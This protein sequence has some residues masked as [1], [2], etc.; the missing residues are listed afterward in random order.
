[1]SDQKVIAVLGATGNQGGSVADTF[2][3]D[4]WRVRTITRN[5][6][7]PK[8]QEL[9]AR[10]AEIA[11]ADLDS[12]SSLRT[13][14]EGAHVVF[15]VSDFWGLYRDPSNADKPRQGQSLNAWAAEHETEQLRNVI[16]AVAGI[17]CVERFIFSSLSGATKWSKGKYTHVYHF[18]SKA[19]AED[20]GRE[21]YPDL[22]KTSILQAGFFVRNFFADPILK[23]QKV[24]LHYYGSRILS[25]VSDETRMRM[26]FYT[27]L[28][29]RL[30]MSS[31]RSLSPRKILDHL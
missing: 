23:P 22:W 7:N 21:K 19:L 24:R 18:D 29:V 20:Y 13:A 8:A 14:F 9:A 12:P 16:D 30:Q 27:S 2:L 11:Q 26:A 25:V 10:G 15:A 28:A 5:I 4:G 31:Y 1:M 3:K 6:S 17:P